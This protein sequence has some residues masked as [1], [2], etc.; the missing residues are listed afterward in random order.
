MNDSKVV[1]ISQDP[2]YKL[3][4]SSRAKYSWIMTII[5]L[6][7]YYGYICLVAFDKEFLG[8]PIGNGVTTLSI[9][10]GL[11]VIIITVIL[12]G[13]YVRKANKEFDA[14]TDKIKKEHE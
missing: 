9:P 7:L 14:L 1:K 13:I 8:R 5:M 12:T 4:V 2:N 6:V 11:G 10:I 3:L